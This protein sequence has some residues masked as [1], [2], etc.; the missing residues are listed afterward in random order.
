MVSTDLLRRDVRML[1]D[2]L[3]EVIT[4]MAGPESLELVGEQPREAVERVD[5]L[6]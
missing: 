3:G 2:M 4:D 1:G 5:A 6:V